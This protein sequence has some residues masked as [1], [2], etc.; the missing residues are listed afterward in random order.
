MRKRISS[1]DK[2]YVHY[3]TGNFDKHRFQQAENIQNS[4]K[5]RYGLWGSPVDSKNSWKEWCLEKECRELSEENCFYFRIR[6]WHVYE[7]CKEEDLEILPHVKV[8]LG[9]QARINTSYY[10]LDFEKIR[11]QEWPYFALDIQINE[12]E[13]KLVGYDCDCILVL[14][15]RDLVEN[16]D[17]KFTSSPITL[18]KLLPMRWCGTVLQNIEV[19]AL[20]KT[21]ENKKYIYMEQPDSYYGFKT[22]V[23]CI[24]DGRIVETCGFT[25]EEAKAVV[26]EVI[27]EELC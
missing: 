6:G 8:S 25:L 20:L 9:F 16:Y 12:V 27:K 15:E 22:I 7:I 21:P 23:A 13:E 1:E 17:A 5:P 3:G 24:T 2:L 10:Y 18:N 14:D 26:K 4:S 11:K 19:S